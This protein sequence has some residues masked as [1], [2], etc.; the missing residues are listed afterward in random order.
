VICAFIAEH[1]ARFRVASIC[2]ALSAHGCKIASRTY[3]AWVSRPPSKR[4]LSGVALTGILAGFY[5]PDEHGRRALE[6]LYGSLKMWA[7]LDREGITMAR[8]TVERLMRAIRHSFGPSKKSP[9]SA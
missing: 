3:Y 4:A 9:C 1:W 2:R 5:M 8:C 7:H 6:S